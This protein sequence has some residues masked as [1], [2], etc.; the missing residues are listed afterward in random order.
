MPNLQVNGA[1]I[2]FEEH[3][4]GPETIVFAHVLLLSGRVFDPQVKAL[5]DRFRCITFDFRGQGQ[6][7]VT[8]SGYDID[9]L[10]AD[11]AGIIEALQCAPCHFVGLSMG[12]FAGLRLA[13]RRPALLKSLVLLA[14][15]A[16]PELKQDVRRY[17]LMAFIAR[18]FGTK[19]VVDRVMPMMFGEKFLN[20]PARTKEREEWRARLIANDRIGVTRAVEGMMTRQGV[21]D[22]LD[23][24][25][26][27]TLIVVGA[28]DA[29]C[30]PAQAE[31]MHAGIPGS[32]LVMI[33]GAGHMSTIEEPAAVNRAL[34]EFLDSF[35]KPGQP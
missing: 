4:A 30:P 11:A 7:Q 17:R 12:G 25:T 13:I 21:Y 23:K 34:E 24:I 14:S 29:M 9:T 3:G 1:E 33:P 26:I 2:Y 15:W 5:Q 32:K 10:T 18:W 22:Q 6:S 27:P 35:Q 19:V 31:R 8:D 20:D 16:D 28:Q